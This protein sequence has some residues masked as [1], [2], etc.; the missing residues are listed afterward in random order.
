MHKFIMVGS[1]EDQD[2]E[3]EEEDVIGKWGMK[4]GEEVEP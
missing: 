2:N 3:E 4:T 1:Y